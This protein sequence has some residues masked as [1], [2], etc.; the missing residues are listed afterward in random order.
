MSKF[1]NVAVMAKQGCAPKVTAQYK[2]LKNNPIWKYFR[3]E[4]LFLKCSEKVKA[5]HPELFPGLLN[6]KSW[7]DVNILRKR[8]ELILIEMNS[9]VESVRINGLGAM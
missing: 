6:A 4:P 9:H 1:N 3:A 7:E 8:N 2:L 5:N